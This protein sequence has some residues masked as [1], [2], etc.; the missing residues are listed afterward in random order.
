MKLGAIAAISPILWVAGDTIVTGEPLFSLT[1]TREATPLTRRPTGISGL[2]TEG[3][4]V[5]GQS[6]RYAV[7][8]AAAIG[9][10]A[11][12]RRGRSRTLSAVIAATLLASAVPVAAGAPLNDRY[13]LASL[14]LLSVAAA[15]AV[16]LAFDRSNRLPWRALGI[17]CGAALLVTASSQVSRFRDN[18]ERLL[19]TAES[20]ADAR[21]LVV[22]RLPC[23]PLVLPNARLR[24]A[25]AVWL[26][27]PVGEIKDGRAS[28]PPGTYLSGTARAMSGVVTLE[29]R[30]GAIAPTPERPVVARQGGWTLRTRC[31]R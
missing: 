13:F 16:A 15:S 26:D 28:S 25:A 14:A 8:L 4:R 20:R 6:L 19:S 23:L 7:L 12:F 29:G 1:H 9:V 17:A 31:P 3:P 22:D 18:R 11:A 5:V 2:I 10:V 30:P 27:V 24:A 21:R